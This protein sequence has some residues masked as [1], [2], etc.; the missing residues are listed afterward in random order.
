MHPIL[1]LHN[2]DNKKTTTSMFTKDT[3]L[4]F[5]NTNKN[6]LHLFKLKSNNDLIG[7]TDDCLPWGEYFESIHKVD[8]QVLAG[9]NFVFIEQSKDTAGNRILLYAKKCPLFDNKKNI[10]GLEGKLKVVTGNYLLQIITLI[11]TDEKRFGKNN[12]SQYL[13]KNSFEN[14]S[15]RESECLFY[16]IRNR[17]LKTIGKL[18]NISP[19]TVETHINNIKK[20]VNC[21]TTSQLIEKAFD[22]G[23]ISII[24]RNFILKNPVILDVY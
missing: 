1:T 11:T 3:S 17:G 12:S 4:R 5:D 20:K 18:L 10:I 7:K 9:K 23:F 15:E 19:R 22:I 24:P 8:K 6:M 13:V 2:T 21:Y 14:L 16:L